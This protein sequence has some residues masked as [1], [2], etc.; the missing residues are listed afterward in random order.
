MKHVDSPV[1]LS[2]N[3][4]YYLYDSE[5]LPSVSTVQKEPKSQETQSEQHTLQTNKDT[6]RHTSAGQEQICENDQGKT[7]CHEGTYKLEEPYQ[8]KT[9]GEK[10][11]L[12]T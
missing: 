4:R 5:M 10:Q 12:Q 3:A 8:N 7:D 9:Q 2:I 6:Q 1:Y 11:T